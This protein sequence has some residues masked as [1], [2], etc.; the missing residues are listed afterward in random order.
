MEPE[1]YKSRNSRSSLIRVRGSVFLIMFTSLL[2]LLSH[3]HC[4]PESCF[5]ETNSFVKVIFYSDTTNN[6]AP[7]DSLTVYGIGV[8]TV[9]LYDKRANVQPALLPLD[10]SDGN[11]VFVIRINGITD[12]ITFNYTTYP[13]LISQ[14]CGY[15]FYHTI[16]DDP[17][18]SRN[19]IKEIITKNRN[20]TTLNE[21]NISIYY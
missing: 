9:R 17:L 12:T 19:I 16:V 3:N 8:D 1:R 20:V 18:Y 6:L 21:E 11:S 2:V 13:H 7:P 10:A 4:T 14:E 15:S 5:E